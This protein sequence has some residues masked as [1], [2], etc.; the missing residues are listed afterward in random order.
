MKGSAASHTQSV[1]DD[2]RHRFKD[3]LALFGITASITY[4]K[5][6]PSCSLRSAVAAE[7]QLHAGCKGGITLSIIS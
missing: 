2:T 7:W 6:D 5:K 4:A 1:N 3:K